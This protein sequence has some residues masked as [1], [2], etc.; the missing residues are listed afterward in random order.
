[1][2]KLRAFTLIEVMISIFVFTTAMLG[3]MAF[4]SH[5][6]SVLFE[7]ESAQFAHSLAFNLIE[8]FNAMSYDSFQKITDDILH[9]QAGE[10]AEATLATNDFFGTNYATSPF[11]MNKNGASYAFYRKI[12][13]QSYSQAT[14]HYAAK[15]TY[16]ATLY[17]IKV[18]VYW[19]KIGHGNANCSD[20]NDDAFNTDCN[21]IMAVL[22]RSNRDH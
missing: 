2:R 11:Y 16:L 20:R 3:Y 4:H 19:P 6:M 17:E 9:K 18:Y 7:N 5:S 15:G 21:E 14:G 13:I 8:E 1:M 22:V 10:L 12:S